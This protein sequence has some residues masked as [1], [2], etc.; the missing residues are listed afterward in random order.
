[1][2]FI[3]LIQTGILTTFVTA[4][5]TIATCIISTVQG[6]KKMKTENFDKIYTSLVNFTE[7]RAEI[8]DKC[9]GLVCNIADSFPERVQRLSEQKW[10]KVCCNA[11]HRMNELLT[12]YSKCLELFLSF[13][14]FL[15][16]DKPIAPIIV[17]ECW[18][19]LTIYEDMVN[20]FDKEEYRI[21]Y[22]QIVTLI[23]FI[24][25]NGKWKDKR[26]LHG[27]LKRNHVFRLA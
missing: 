9:N 4:C 10:E 15:Y 5:V 13:S 26:R 27:Y 7:K 25:L 1:M 12:E 17:S 21:M 18:A 14:H 11:Y 16:R 3:G 20:M 23:Q 19:F 8:L 6:Y 22:E 2:N 24:R